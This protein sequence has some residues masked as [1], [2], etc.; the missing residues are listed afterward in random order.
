MY[1]FFS[2]SSGNGFGRVVA[3]ASGDHKSKEQSL[4]SKGRRPMYHTTYL[5]SSAFPLH[6][7]IFNYD[8][9]WDCYDELTPWLDATAGV[10]QPK[11][12][13]MMDYSKSKIKSCLGNQWV[14]A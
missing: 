11:E 3:E 6:Y 1:S 7:F 14:E 4:I 8:L 13:S 2:G 9:Q 10:P 12:P 5:L